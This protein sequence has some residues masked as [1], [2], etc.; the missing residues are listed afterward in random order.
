MEAKYKG[1]NTDER[2][3]GVLNLSVNKFNITFLTN[4]TFNKTFL[5]DFY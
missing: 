2:L 3:G 1:L 4:K 5:N